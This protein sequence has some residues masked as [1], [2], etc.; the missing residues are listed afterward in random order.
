[1]LVLPPQQG[2]DLDNLALD[3]LPAVHEVLRPHI[4]PRRLTPRLLAEGDPA[5][6]QTRLEHDQ[7]LKRLKSLNAQ[8]VTAY[9]V[10]ELKRHPEHPP[11]G[12]LRLTLS[13]FF[14]P[15]RLGRRDSPLWIRRVVETEAGHRLMIL[16]FPGKDAK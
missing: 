5:A 15:W 3:V 14:N 12:L 1:M 2:K 10:V 9:Q 6:T 8:S 13:L 7:A 4:E 11:Q 16:R